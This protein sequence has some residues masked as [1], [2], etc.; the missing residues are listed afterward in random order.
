MTHTAHN[1]DDR[2]TLKIDPQAELIS[3]GI[4]GELDDKNLLRLLD[5]CENQAHAQ[6]WQTWHIIG[7][8]LRQ[9]PCHAA[10]LA[11]RVAAQ[12]ALE[13]AILAPKP[14]RQTSKWLVP[15]AA[16]VAAVALVSWSALHIPMSGQ[17]AASAQM[18]STAPGSV[19]PTA[20]MTASVPAAGNK[21]QVAQIDQTRLTSFIAAHRDFAPGA[22]SP[23]MD[24]TYQISTGSSR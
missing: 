5:L 13:P 12:I 23:L 20:Q 3:A 19:A 9:T 18:A 15:M 6:H 11:Q 16:S 8:S 7:D 21:P 10:G 4:D 22:N 1:C 14:Q 2:G 17:H 24:A